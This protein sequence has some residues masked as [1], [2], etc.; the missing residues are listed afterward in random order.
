MFRILLEFG[1]ERFWRCAQASA[2][3]RSRR[4]RARWARWPSSP[5][6]S[7]RS[8]WRRRRRRLAS[9]ERPASRAASSVTARPA[10]AGVRVAASPGWYRMPWPGRCAAVR[11]PPRRQ[12]ALVRERA[13]AGRRVGR[14]AAVVGAP[15]SAC[16]IL[17]WPHCGLAGAGKPGRRAPA[18]FCRGNGCFA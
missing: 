3:R 7:P 17:C 5:T 1:H 16:L 10:P 4:A 8:W 2:Y 11:S 12:C 18:P 13:R 14:G 6:T 15:P 9:P